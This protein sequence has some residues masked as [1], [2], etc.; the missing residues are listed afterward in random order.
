MRKNIAIAAL[1]GLGGGMLPLTSVAETDHSYSINAGLFS[2]YVWRGMTQTAK[3]PALQAGVDYA[4]TS[5][6]YVGTWASNVSWLKDGAGSLYDSGGTVELDLYGGYRGALGETGIGYDLGLIRYL[7]PG[8]K[9]SGSPG[10]NAT[11][12]Y[13][14]LSYGWL[15]ARYSLAASDQAWGFD[16]VRGTAYYELNADIPFGES[17]VSLNLHVGSFR[18]DGRAGGISNDEYDYEDWKVGFTKTWDNGINIGG[19]WT[20]NNA[21]TEDGWEKAMTES[22][23]TVFVQKVF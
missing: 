14:G 17:G 8:S 9:R 6:L 15:S 12:L 1:I 7:Y 16:D 22:Q 10:A 2:Q 11:E 18:F 21:D 19:Y 5:G 23:F 13:A 20:D 4:H 3:Q